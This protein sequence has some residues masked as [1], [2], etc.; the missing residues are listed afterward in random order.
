MQT[1]GGNTIKK[2]DWESMDLGGG[3]GGA[4]AA[5]IFK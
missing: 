2:T 3:G 4:K 1:A 5:E